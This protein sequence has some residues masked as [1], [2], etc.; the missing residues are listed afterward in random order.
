MQH[1]NHMYYLLHNT[2]HVFHLQ[3]KQSFH[4]YIFNLINL[5]KL[6]NSAL[7]SVSCWLLRRR[8]AWF[9]L[10]F[11]EF[12]RSICIIT[13]FFFDSCTKTT[14]VPSRT[15]APPLCGKSW[16][17][18]CVAGRSEKLNKGVCRIKGARHIES[19]SLNARS[20]Y[21][22]CAQSACLTK[23]THPAHLLCTSTTAT[24]SHQKQTE[25]T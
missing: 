4:H 10:E 5:L 11:V 19:L 22:T 12:E 20:K 2:N 8:N 6:T 14:T 24:S 13:F 21:Y 18:R 25:W 1:L 3:H 23:V 9:N 7:D 16:S 15:P 17:L